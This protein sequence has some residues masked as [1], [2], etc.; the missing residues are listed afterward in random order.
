MK[1]LTFVIP[2]FGKS[3]PLNQFYYLIKEIHKE[4]EIKIVCVLPEKKNL[5]FS[6][7]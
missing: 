3:G 5:S 6:C 7:E 1:K 2:H 4:Y